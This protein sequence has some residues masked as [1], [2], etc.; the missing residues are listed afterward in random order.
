[1]V[2][3]KVKAGVVVQKQPYMETGFEE[4]PDD[5][6]CGM[7]KTGTTFVFPPVIPLKYDPTEQE[8]LI[9]AL[10]SAITPAD[11]NTARMRLINNAP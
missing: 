10:R 7:I 2:Y 1:M 6:V 9:E 11:Y 5:I 4:V 8:V 3:V